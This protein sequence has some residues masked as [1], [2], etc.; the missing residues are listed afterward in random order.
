MIFPKRLTF[1]SAGKDKFFAFYKGHMIEL[2]SNPL[3]N[4]YVITIRT[5]LHSHSE[6]DARVLAELFMESFPDCSP[7]PPADKEAQQQ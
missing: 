2:K 1:A 3:I 5:P 7:L 4:G 6:R